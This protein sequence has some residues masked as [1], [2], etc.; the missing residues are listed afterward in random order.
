MG[1]GAAR[2]YGGHRGHRQGGFTLLEILVVVAIIAMLALVVLVVPTW[3]D[4]SRRLDDTAGKLS[5][6]LIALNE[7]SLFSG[8]LLAL[9]LT[10]SG[11]TPLQFDVARRRFVPAG[12]DSLQPFTLPPGLRLNWTSNQPEE[13]MGSGDQSVTP[14]LKQAAKSL[15]AQD[16]FGG[17]GD[18]GGST[19][20][21]NGGPSQSLPQVYFFP[22]GETSP[23]TF[24]L[25]VEDNA[26][27]VVKRRLS[28]LG[29]VTDPA[30]DKKNTKHTGGDLP[31]PGNRA[32]GS[33]SAINP[34]S[35]GAGGGGP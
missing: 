5:D 34:S 23:M 24:T 30:R 1:I 14:T 21:D 19:G 28:A 25:R 13:Q 26:D 8:K 12:D 2:G 17:Q 33:G 7:D 27:Q 4:D 22:S 10:H 11:W 9:R 16:P 29:T 6:T 31:R 15:I 3:S 20:S 35:G 18:G 32:D